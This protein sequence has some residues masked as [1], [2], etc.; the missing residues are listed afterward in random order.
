MQLF[1]KNIKDE[2]FKILATQVKKP[3]LSVQIGKPLEDRV[4]II[5]TVKADSKKGMITDMLEIR[6]DHPKQPVTRI[7]IAARIVG[8]IQFSRKRIF[9]KNIEPGQTKELEI[10]ANI[11]L[12]ANTEELMISEITSD[13]KLVTGKVLGKRPDGTT[14]ILF[15]FVAPEKQ[16][17]HSGTIK[18]K[19]NIEAEP[20]TTLPYSALVR[21]SKR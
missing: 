17:Y 16:G 13:K 7:S 11:P 10:T 1:M 6:T 5:L 2:P 21:S 20:E 14:R 3:E 18:L 4:P 15:T 19:T 8:H 9:F 12:S